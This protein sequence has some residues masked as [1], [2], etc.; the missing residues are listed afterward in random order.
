MKNHI[1]TFC[2][3]GLLIIIF[4]FTAGLSYGQGVD[5][6]LKVGSGVALAVF[7]NVE[8]S[9]GN[10]S[11]DASSFADPSLSMGLNLAIT[12]F[13]DKQFSLGVE[14]G[15]IT[16]GY[17]S[18]QSNYR[19]TYYY[20]QLPLVCSVQLID[21]LRIEPTVEI[22]TILSALSNSFG[23]KRDLKDIG[24]YS[25][26][27]EISVGGSLRYQLS[28]RIDLG[29]KYSRG[30][31][32]ISEISYTDVNGVF[33]ADVEEKTQYLQLFA[34]YNFTSPKISKDK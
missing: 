6:G 18:N 1:L 11:Y 3:G 30:L 27:R 25:N 16:K 19:L 8:T 13:R 32:S 33:L 26:I 23:S 20:F 31:S 9:P 10:E 21:K 5:L 24:L 7:E 22:G 17:K 28:N 14:P 4:L 12:F 2:L 34:V 15:I 29:F